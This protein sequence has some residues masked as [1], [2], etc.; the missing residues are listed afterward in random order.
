MKQ[1]LEA[2]K[3]QNEFS[4][5]SNDSITLHQNIIQSNPILQG[6]YKK[7]YEEILPAVRDTEHLKLPMIELGC[8]AS[9]IEKYIPGVIKSDVVAHS[10]VERVISCESLP[11]EKESLRALFLLGVIHHLE[12]PEKFL[13]E[14]ERCLAKGGRLVFLEPTNSP[15]NQI[16]VNR[17]SAYEKHDATVKSWKSDSA[18]GRLSNGNTA[19]P[20]VIF[21][22][23]RNLLTQ[24]FPR[25]RLKS[26]RYHTLLAYFI[27]GGMAFKPF[28][29]KPLAFLV[30]WIEFLT[31]PLHRLL[32]TE[33]TVDFEKI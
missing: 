28:L 26:I 29:P 20:W 24:K 11:F 13:S 33:M 32:G 14:A 30:R 2:R 1:L 16:I 21:I 27:S 18:K 6:V 5:D 7:W 12:D 31:S 3:L 4:I 10:N 15:L 9:H 8:G 23:D 17:F 25:L 22:R 19:L